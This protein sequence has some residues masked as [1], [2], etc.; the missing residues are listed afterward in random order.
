MTTRLGINSVVGY[1]LDDKD[2]NR[3]LNSVT[4]TR[5]VKAEKT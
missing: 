3:V 2:V 5:L 1:V 4:R